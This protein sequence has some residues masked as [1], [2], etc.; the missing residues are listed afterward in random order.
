MRYVRHAHQNGPV[1]RTTEEFRRSTG[2]ALARCMAPR[3]VDLVDD[4]VLDITVLEEEA[5][6]DSASRYRERPRFRV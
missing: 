1:K 6:I 5:P 3:D 4:E 2:A